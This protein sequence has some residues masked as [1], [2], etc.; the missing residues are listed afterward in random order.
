[1]VA[2]SI[3]VKGIYDCIYYSSAEEKEHRVADGETEPETYYYDDKDVLHLRL[4]C[5]HVDYEW[6]TTEVDTMRNGEH[7]TYEVPIAVCSNWDCGKVLDIDPPEPDDFDDSDDW[8][9]E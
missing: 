9:D 8:R 7:D 3:K 5:D 1:M 2:V 6:D 4:T